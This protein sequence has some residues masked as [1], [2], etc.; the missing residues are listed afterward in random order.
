VAFSPG[1]VAPPRR[2]GRP[3]VFVSHGVDDPVLPVERCSRRIVPA[4]RRAGHRVEYRELAG[5]HVVPPAVAAEAARW[6]VG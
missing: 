6:L 2:L 5:G 4:L 1:F 3:D